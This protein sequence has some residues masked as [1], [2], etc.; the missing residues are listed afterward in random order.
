MDWWILIDL[1]S[2]CF[3]LNDKKD[4]VYRCVFKFGYCIDFLCLFVFVDVWG[5]WG[6]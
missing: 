6:W 2:D 1:K 5:C 4:L 3:V